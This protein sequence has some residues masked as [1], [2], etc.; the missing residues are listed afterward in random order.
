MKSLILFLS[1]L[2]IPVLC[3]AGDFKVYVGSLT[4]SPNI[5]IPTDDGGYIKIDRG[6]VGEIRKSGVDEF[7]CL[8]EE[9]FFNT[10]I[11]I[12]YLIMAGQLRLASYTTTQLKALT[13]IV[14]EGGV[15]VYCTNSDIYVST[16][17]AKGAWKNA[18]TGNAP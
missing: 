2:I 11:D 4:A 3:F 18:R 16:G 12:N 14:G 7:W 13:P 15:I 17:T 5:T 9:S 6:G 8:G 1:I 10:L